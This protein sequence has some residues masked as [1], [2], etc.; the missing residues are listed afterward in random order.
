[1]IFLL[2]EVNTRQASESPRRDAD[3][4]SFDGAHWLTLKGGFSVA[5]NSIQFKRIDE[6]YIKPRELG[7][8][9]DDICS[10]VYF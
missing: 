1:M 10:Y 6:V 9:L 4:K 5:F 3:R 7:T 2:R 8:A